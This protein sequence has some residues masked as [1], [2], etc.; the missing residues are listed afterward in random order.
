M[1]P[2]VNQRKEQIVGRKLL[3]KVSMWA[4]IMEWFW[5]KLMFCLPIVTK[6]VQLWQHWFYNFTTSKILCFPGGPISLS[7]TLSLIES[8]PPVVFWHS[9]LNVPWALSEFHTACPVTVYSRSLTGNI[10][11]TSH[12]T[13]HTLL[14]N[15]C[16]RKEKLCNNSHHH[17]H[18]LR[19]Q[20][21]KIR[22]FRTRITMADWS[23]R[24]LASIS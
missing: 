1:P 17:H 15:N 6:M 7:S 16:C 18:C 14:T 23:W 4:A 13:H 22:T 12:I 24:H 10:R 21:L 19:F 8:L 3:I 11:H 20:M 2:A 5:F 9:H